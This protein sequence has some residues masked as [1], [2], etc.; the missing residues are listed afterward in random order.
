MTD[1]PNR[2]SLE[3][4]SDS[5]LP[6]DKSKMSDAQ[7]AAKDTAQDAKGTVENATEGA[8]DTVDSATG[9]A[10]GGAESQGGEQPRPLSL[11]PLSVPY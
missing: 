9:G 11:F 4:N 7:D 8:K 5:L 6:T 10:T 2:I 1:H 3:D